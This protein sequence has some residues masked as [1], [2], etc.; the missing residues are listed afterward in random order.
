MLRL[1]I[2]LLIS[3]ALC[4]VAPAKNLFDEINRKLNRFSDKLSQELNG[5]S[6][7]QRVE[8][9]SGTQVANNIGVCLGIGSDG[10]I[11]FRDQCTAETICNADNDC[12]IHYRWN[13]EWMIANLRSGR[14]VRFIGFPVRETIV[15]GFPCVTRENGTFTFCFIAN[16]RIAQRDSGVGTSNDDSDLS[17]TD[18]EKRFNRQVSGTQIRAMRELI[19]E[20]EIKRFFD[21]HVLKTLKPANAVGACRNHHLPLMAA[22][23]TPVPGEVIDELRKRCVSGAEFYGRWQAEREG[24]RQAYDFLDVPATLDGLRK[25]NWFLPNRSVQKLFPNHQRE[26][27]M[28]SFRRTVYEHREAALTAARAEID[29]AFKTAVPLS[30]SADKAIALCNLGNSAP[31]ELTTAC[32]TK[33]DDLF[34]KS[35]TARC[36]RAVEQSGASQSFLDRMIASSGSRYENWT[37]RRM[38]CAGVGNYPA[39]RIAIEQAWFP[40]I[41]WSTLRIYN[42]DN[43]LILDVAL[44]VST[45]RDGRSFRKLLFDI[46]TG[47]NERPVEETLVVARIRRVGPG[48]KGRNSDAVIGCVLNFIRC[49]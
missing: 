16:D 10:Q 11:L 43:S 35:V 31:S 18:F 4:Q 42:G 9:E 2:T 33:R 22:I 13:D 37:V 34:Q 24:V 12:D 47:E 38:I 3:V 39:Y 1:L 28:R 7:T 36:D 49:K 17:N 15:D 45:P 40:S 46:A 19:E 23:V 25:N 6:S 27:F 26:I 21:G 5:G 41:A 44:R 48:I 32:K 20:S 14:P 30:E 29:L 8:R